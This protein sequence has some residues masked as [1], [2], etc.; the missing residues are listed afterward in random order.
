MTRA[1]AAVAAARAARR[2]ARRPCPRP[3]RRRRPT[4]TSGP[5]SR[6]RASAAPAPSTTV[7]VRAA[8]VAQRRQRPAQP[9]GAVVV[10]HQRL[11]HAHPPPLPRR[12]QQSVDDRSGVGSV[13]ERL[14]VQAGERLVVRRAEPA[15]HQRRSPARRPGTGRPPR[16]PRLRSGPASRRAAHGPGRGRRRHRGTT[17]SPRARPAVLDAAHGAVE[18][19]VGLG[20]HV[21]GRRHAPPR[22]GVLRGVEQDDVGRRR[23]GGGVRGQS[24]IAS[25][26]AA[27]PQ[28]PSARTPERSV[29]RSSRVRI[30][31]RCHTAE[32][33]GLVQHVEMDGRRLAYHRAG[34]GV[35]LVLLHGGWSDGR[36]WTRQLAV[37]LRPLRRGRARRPR[38][39]RLRR[40]S[41]PCRAGLVRRRRGR[42]RD[43][44]GPRPGAPRRVVL[45]WRPGPGRRATSSR[46]RPVAGAR[47]RVRRLGRL[48]APRRGRRQAD[49]RPG[50]DGPPTGASGPTR[51]STSSSTPP[52]T[53]TSW[54]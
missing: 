51:T 12:E 45:R 9:R 23:R 44:P 32:A 53:P 43:R 40:P 25:S 31:P 49:P 6:A 11:G 15:H 30:P 47:R 3:S 37:A 2:A 42:P 28:A 34:A 20:E 54:R 21:S 33:G 36:L 27:P 52:S 39:R 46:S 17:A 50:R 29:G 13:I 18:G 48:A 24:R 4:A 19:D 41:G 35:P 7:T 8:A 16:R 22:A 1:A 14:G 38:L 5:S 26:S 10:A